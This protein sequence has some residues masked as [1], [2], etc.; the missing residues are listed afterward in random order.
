MALLIQNGR[1]Y[2]EGRLERA[3]LLVEG[4]RI[5]A[6]GEGLPQAPGARVFDA[7]G[8]VVSPGFTDLHVHLREP[9]FSHKE[10]VASGTAAAAAGGFTTVCAMPNVSPVPDSPARLLPQA[11]RIAR[12]ARVRVVPYAA[13]TRGRRG[14][15]LS[16]VAALAPHVAGFSDDGRG[17][18][19]EETMRAAME[20]VAAAGSFVAAH[21]EVEALIPA[22]GCCHDGA[23]ARAQGFPGIPSESEYAEIARDIRLAAETGCRLHICHL[24]T[25]EGAALVR[26]ARKRGLPVT[27]EAAPHNLLLCD[28]EIPEDEGRFKM[29]PPLRAADDRAALVEALLDGTITAIAT[30]HAPHTAEEKSGGFRGSLYGVVGLETAFP[31]LYTG[32]TEPGLLPLGLLL[33]LLTAGPQEILGER[34]T[35]APGEEASLTV[36]D[37]RTARKVEPERFLSRGRATPFAGRTLRG[38]PAL[39]LYRGKEVYRRWPGI[40]TEG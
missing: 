12:D 15:A 40:Q 10:T 1:V 34:R 6:I 25:K 8:C 11:R 17:V 2:R 26:K 30:D 5:A 20:R 22:G 33:K 37:L 27:C 3:D 35:L 4:G 16:E 38:W 23:F 31:A 28:G 18:R 13:I 24:S 32:L 14:E 39:T 7:S 9:G 36:L 19:S 29:N 21:C